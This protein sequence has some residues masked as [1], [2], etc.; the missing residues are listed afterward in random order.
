MVTLVTA[1]NQLSRVLI[2]L[3]EQGSHFFGLTKFHDISMI[4]PVFF[5]KFSGIFFFIFKV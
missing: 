5:S 4:V 1:G 3:G 2:K